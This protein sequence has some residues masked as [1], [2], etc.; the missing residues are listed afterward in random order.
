MCL[1]ITIIAC[2]WFWFLRSREILIELVVAH[3]NYYFLFSQASIAAGKGQFTYAKL[4]PTLALKRCHVC[5]YESG[6]TC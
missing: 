5:T 4:E 6:F 3:S 1:L 2:K